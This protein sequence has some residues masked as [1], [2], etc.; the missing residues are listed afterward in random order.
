MDKI[1]RG[2]REYGESIIII[3]QMPSTILASAI[4]N[5]ANK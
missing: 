5:T 4:A 1:F 2:I 3:D